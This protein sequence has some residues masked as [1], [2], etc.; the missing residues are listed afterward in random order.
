M[1]SEEC[2]LW[3]VDCGVWSVEYIVWSVEYVVSGSPSIAGV[4]C[5]E[6]C[7]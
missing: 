4:E 2:G 1:G 3:I 6:L 5:V 7:S